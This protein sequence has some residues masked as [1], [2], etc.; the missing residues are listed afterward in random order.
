[1]RFIS[2]QIIGRTVKITNVFSGQNP[3]SEKM[4]AGEGLPVSRPKFDPDCVLSYRNWVYF[5]YSLDAFIHREG[6]ETIQFQKA[7][8][9]P[10]SFRRVGAGNLV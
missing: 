5:S 1:M 9:M 10:I 8:R 3:L 2:S 4:V 7:Q 6:K